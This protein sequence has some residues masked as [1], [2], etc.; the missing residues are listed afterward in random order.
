MVLILLT[1]MLLANCPGE[2]E[3]LG[4]KASEGMETAE[5]A[6]AALLQAL[7]QESAASLSSASPAFAESLQDRLSWIHVSTHKTPPSYSAMHCH[8]F[9]FNGFC[10]NGH[11]FHIDFLC[12]G[13]VKA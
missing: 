3:K 5:V 11:C 1:M 2:G 4:Q 8:C 7:Q 9:Q 6:R 10:S 13:S 12:T